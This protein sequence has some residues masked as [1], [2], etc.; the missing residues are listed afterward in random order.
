[1]RVT[2]DSKAE[3]ITGASGPD[4]SIY[5]DFKVRAHHP[6]RTCMNT[7]HERSQTI[8]AQEFTLWYKSLFAVH[9]RACMSVCCTAGERHVGLRT[10]A[11]IRSHQHRMAH[12]ITALHGHRGREHNDS[13]GEQL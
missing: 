9:T 6:A 13:I 10:D 3:G 11:G 1:M 7:F 2:A 12:Q 5:C 8:P 4:Y